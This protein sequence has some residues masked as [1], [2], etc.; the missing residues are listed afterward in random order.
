MTAMD[1]SQVSPGIESTPAPAVSSLR[2]R[3]EQLAADTAATSVTSRPSSTYGYLSPD[4]SGSRPRANSAFIEA[5]Q[6]LHALRPASSSSDLKSGT[7]RPP[8]P[9]PTRHSGSSSPSPR[10][11]PLLRPVIIPD[12]SPSPLVTESILVLDSRPSSSVNPTAL[13][14]KPP[15]PPP[16][17]EHRSESTAS[18]RSS[19]VSS[20]VS[21]FG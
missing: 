21:K 1:A 13:A 14:R 10:P 11:S 9:P 18:Q 6:D 4:P 3:F 19:A 15:P 7:K 17:L 8:P 16:L 12:P 2:S 5:K 20:L